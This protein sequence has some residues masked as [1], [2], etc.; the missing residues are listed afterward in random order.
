MENAIMTRVTSLSLVALAV[1]C[2]VTVPALAQ[3]RAQT[4]LADARKA[5]GKGAQGQINA[6]SVAATV[7]RVVPAAGNMELSSEVQLDVLFPDKYRRTETISIAQLSRTVTT[8]LNG[9][10]LFY[11]DGG[12]AAMMGMDPT[13]PG[14][15]RDETIKSLKSDMFRMVTV[16]LLAP[17][18]TMPATFTSAGVAEAPDGKADVVD[19]KGPDTLNLRLFLDTGTHRLLMATYQSESV[20]PKQ[21]MEVTQK[22]MAQ[23]KA[24]PQG[25]VKALR[26]EIEKLPKK[27]VTVQMH[28]SE[29]KTMNGL[30]LPTKISVDAAQGQEEWTITSFK[31]N[32]SLSPDR[33]SKK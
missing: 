26:E 4:V 32:P 1:A 31:V 6:L 12:A 15:Q 7:R 3:D 33:F 28:F 13:K 24:D 29:P 25:T 5:L 27:S 10:D 22:Y 9:A 30:T 17:P 21:I 11:D 23:A 14:P 20:D 18:A 8:G 16:W 2:A 19:V